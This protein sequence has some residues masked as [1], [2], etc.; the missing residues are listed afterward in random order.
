MHAAMLPRRQSRKPGRSSCCTS[1]VTEHMACCTQLPLDMPSSVS[2][3]ELVVC[4]AGPDMPLLQD[5]TGEAALSD[6]LVALAQRLPRARFIIT[7][8]GTKGAVMLHRPAQ[9]PAQVR[10]QV[11][12]AHTA[13]CAQ[14]QYHIWPFL[15]MTFYQLTLLPAAPQHQGAMHGAAC[16]EPVPTQ[17]TADTLPTPFHCHRQ[18]RRARQCQLSLQPA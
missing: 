4:S 12:G 1:S 3:M 13:A 7:T 11:Q 5:W 10:D 8:R 6:A 18:Q 14:C 2:S 17:D 15:P 16:I 9:Q